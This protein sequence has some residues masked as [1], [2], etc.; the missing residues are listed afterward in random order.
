MLIARRSPMGRMRTST[1][2]SPAGLTLLSTKTRPTATITPC[3]RSCAWKTNMG[4]RSS[5]LIPI[6]MR[7]TSRAAICREFP[8]H[9]IWNMT[10]V[11]AHSTAVISLTQATSTSC[12][13]SCTRTVRW[14]GRSL[15]D[16]RFPALPWLK[17]VCRQGH[18]TEPMCSDW[19]AVATGQIS[20]V[21]SATRR[22]RQRGLTRPPSRRLS[23]PGFQDQLDRTP[24]LATRARTQLEV[25]IT[26]A[27][28]P[29]IQLR[30]ESYNTFNHTEF[31]NVSTGF[32]NSNF[33]QL[34]S[35]Y[36]PRVLQFGA[37]FLF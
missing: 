11:Q 17:A 19:E 33:G 16:G 14:Q 29:R 23:L 4:S 7:L 6:R 36:D 26:S 34:T 24:A 21:M 2:S 9:S 32:T 1:G 37:K 35:T 18:L 27:E 22:S 31:Q 30:A 20:P 28:G 13:S 5:L 10:V 3:S 25:R 8:T 15:A 12:R